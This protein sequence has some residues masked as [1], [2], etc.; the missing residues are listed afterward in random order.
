MPIFFLKLLIPAATSGNLWYL[1]Y[2]VTTKC[3]FRHNLIQIFQV[4][5]SFSFYLLV[6]LRTKL[7]FTFP[8]IGIKFLG[9]RYVQ[10]SFC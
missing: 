5:L 9:E 7:D 4:S 10:C 2:L 6:F 8:K 3:Q 1:L